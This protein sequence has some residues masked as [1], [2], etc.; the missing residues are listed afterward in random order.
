[1]KLE[2]IY[3]FAQWL[4]LADAYYGGESGKPRSSLLLDI[5]GFRDEVGFNPAAAYKG[6]HSPATFAI[7]YNEFRQDANCL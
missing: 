6:G 3:S 5:Y 2:I 4:R 1:M 7:A